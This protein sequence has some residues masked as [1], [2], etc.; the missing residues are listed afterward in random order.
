MLREEARKESVGLCSLHA[1]APDGCMSDAERELAIVDAGRALE[2]AQ[3]RAEAVGS[4]PADLDTRDDC[5]R[6]MEALIRGRSD[7]QRQRM[8]AAQAERMRNEPG[9]SF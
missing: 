8:E 5:R 6:Y 9:A 2:V 3:A 7:A 4:V 1:S